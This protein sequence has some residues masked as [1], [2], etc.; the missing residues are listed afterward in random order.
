MNFETLNFDLRNPYLLGGIVIVILVI[1]IWWH[2]SSGTSNDYEIVEE[3]RKIHPT[4]EEIQEKREFHQRAVGIPLGDGPLVKL[5]EPDSEEAKTVP[6][7]NV[8]NYPVQQLF[9]NK[10]VYLIDTEHCENM[11]K[12]FVPALN[13]FEFS[14]VTPTTVHMRVFTKDEEDVDL[15]YDLYYTLGNDGCLLFS[16]TESGEDIFSIN[17]NKSI[18]LLQM[19]K[20]ITDGEEFSCKMEMLQ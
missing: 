3:Y 16:D 2:A 10:W 9:S 18:R 7:N 14:K 6:T 17:E 5:V 13:Y 11:Y 15:E 20:K 4:P 8:G 19:E 12:M 1:T